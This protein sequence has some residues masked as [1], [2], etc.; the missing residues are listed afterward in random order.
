MKAQRPPS[1]EAIT[2]SSRISAQYALHGA[3]DCG[4]TLH[5]KV[6]IYPLAAAPN[7]N[8]LGDYWYGGVAD[9]SGKALIHDAKHYHGIAYT[10][11]LPDQYLDNY[12]INSCVE[13]RQPVIFGGIMF[14]HFAHFLVESLCRLYAYPWLKEAKPYILFLSAWGVPR[15]LEERNYAHQVLEGFSI[16]P[17]RIIIASSPLMVRE[18]AIPIQR[19]GYGFL[20]KPD[21]IFVEFVKSFKFPR[22]LPKGYENADKIYVSRPSLLRA[23]SQ[24][25][26]RYLVQYLDSEGYQVFYPEKHSLY[27]QLNVYS[28]AKKI[29][30]AEGGAIQSCVLLPELQAEVAVICRRRDSRRNIP[31]ATACIQG[32]GKKILWIDCVRG[33][34]QFGIE[35]WAV[36][37][38]VDWMSVGEQLRINDFTTKSFPIIDEKEY[39]SILKSDLKQYLCEIVGNE[40]FLNYMLSL[41]TI[42]PAWTGPS[43]LIDPRCNQPIWASVDQQTSNL[44]SNL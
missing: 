7:E 39:E 3:Q 34:F 26:E 17:E 44:N 41:K 36:L 28:S 33:Q 35:T 9:M 29:I 13:I 5:T 18:M 42:I 27:E 20:H 8:R 12:P 38:D 30:F 25:G 16:P 37:A 32:Y 19:Y 10:Q 23:G 31:V 11:S 24:V 14:N 1:I 22:V 4:V 6:I 2:L 21:N 43:H 40:E 15:Y